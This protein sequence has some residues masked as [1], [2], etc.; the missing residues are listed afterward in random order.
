MAIHSHAEA[1]DVELVSA[2]ITGVT[3]CAEC[4]AKTTGVP[5][6][7]VQATLERI[8]G[9]LVVT[10]RDSRCARCLAATKVFHLV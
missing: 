7:R 10:W 8:A 6:L 2:A 5:L 9:M 1:N 3:L 4:I